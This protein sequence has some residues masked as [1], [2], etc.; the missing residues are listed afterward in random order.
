MTYHIKGLDPAPY[1]HLFGADAETLAAAGAVRVCATHA[2]G[3]P[4]RIT[5]D[6]ARVGQDVLLLP[7]VSQP[8]NT[9]FRATHAIYLTEG[10]EI[11]FDAKDTL[12]PAMQRRPQSLRAFDAKG[13]MRAA[14]IAEGAAI[15]ALIARL[16]DDPE[17]TELHA[18]NARQGC[19]MARIT[20]A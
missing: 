8:A 1:H 16:F 5:L 2:P 18:H 17:V 11:A 14:D 7:H 6:D 4:D 9:P 13:M 3:F 15:D 19:F 10:A 12:P 20:R